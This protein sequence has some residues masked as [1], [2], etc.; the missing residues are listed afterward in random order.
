MMYGL[1]DS[2]FR[3]LSIKFNFTP[4]KW[5]DRAFV[6]FLTGFSETILVP[7]ERVQTLLSISEY[8]LK[9]KNTFHIIYELLIHCGIKELFRGVVYFLKIYLD[10]V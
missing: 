6:G 7:F 4:N 5:Y 10:H 8:N 3:Y 2:Y 9:F 1:Y